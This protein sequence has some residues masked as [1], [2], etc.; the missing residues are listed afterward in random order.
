MVVV[1][2]L[3]GENFS[4]L[5]GYNFTLLGYCVALLDL[6]SY[7]FRS[8]RKKNKTKENVTISRQGHCAERHML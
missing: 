6:K 5:T 1:N 7:Q 4:V 8:R 2:E 3:V